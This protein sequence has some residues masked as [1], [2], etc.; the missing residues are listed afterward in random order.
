MEIKAIIYHIL[1]GFTIKPYDKTQIP[2]QIEKSAANWITKI[3]LE[4]EPRKSKSE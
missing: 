2:V 1:T 4:F 3:H